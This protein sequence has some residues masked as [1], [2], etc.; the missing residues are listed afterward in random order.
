MK[1]LMGHVQALPLARL[2][3]STH[4][5]S[6]RAILSPPHP[7]LWWCLGKICGCHNWG[8]K[9]LL[10]SNGWGPE[11]LFNPSQCPGLPPQ[12]IIC[13]EC[14]KCHGG[15]PALILFWPAGAPRF[16]LKQGLY[17]GHL[18]VLRWPRVGQAGDP[19]WALGMKPQIC[20]H[21]PHYTPGVMASITS[22]CS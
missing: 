5:F 18:C 13:P 6:P 17:P 4:L 3:V 1:A 21:S 16:L 8:W 2:A 14:W 9:G 12:R 19:R 11:M 20:A 15:D 22:L 7:V 10:E